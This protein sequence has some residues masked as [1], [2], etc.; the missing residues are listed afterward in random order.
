MAA[1]HDDD[2]NLQRFLQ[3]AGQGTRE[4]MTDVPDRVVK[5]IVDW[6]VA[7]VATAR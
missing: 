6:V 4:H 7:R 5:R 3:E 1:L 2:G